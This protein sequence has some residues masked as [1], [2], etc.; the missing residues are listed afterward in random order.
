VN[1]KD[2][3]AAPSVEEKMHVI[4]PVLK[5]LKP[6]QHPVVGGILR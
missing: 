5:T 3:P 1:F 2:D 4:L 6:F